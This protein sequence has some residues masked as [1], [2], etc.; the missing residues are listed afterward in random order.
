MFPFIKKVARY[1]TVTVLSYLALLLGTFVLVEFFNASPTPAYIVVLTL[2][3]IG[4]YFASSHYVFKSTEHRK[5]Y[6]RFI[7]AV[8]VFWTLN[9]GAYALLV[10]WLGIQYLLSVVLNI[11]I[12]GGLRYFVYQKWVFKHEQQKP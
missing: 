3:Y 5:Q 10:E 9:A 11:L 8:I 1:G 2:V 12:F 7:V 6:K 4:V